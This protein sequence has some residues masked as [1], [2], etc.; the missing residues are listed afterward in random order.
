MTQGAMNPTALIN[1][2]K[3]LAEQFKHPSVE[4]PKIIEARKQDVDTLIE[5]TRSLLDGAHALT[6]KEADLLRNAVDEV[7]SVVK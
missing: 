2:I 7:S 3:N 4:I 5:A 6:A 1:E